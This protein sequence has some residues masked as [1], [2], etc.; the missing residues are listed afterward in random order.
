M[1]TSMIIGLGLGLGVGVG[2]NMHAARTHILFA[3]IEETIII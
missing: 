3:V 1:H 2:F